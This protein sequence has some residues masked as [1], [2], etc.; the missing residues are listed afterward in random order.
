MKLLFQDGKKKALT[1]SYDDGTM[2]DIRF[3][4][5][6]DKNS[7]RCTFNISSGR[8][9]EEEPHELKGKMTKPTA[10]A[11]LKGT[12]H[13]VAL[14]GYNHLS[15]TELSDEEI[16]FQINEDRKNLEKD[17]GKVIRGFAFPYGTY[18][19]HVLEILQKLGITYAR[20]IYSTEKF[21]L[22]KTWLPLHPTCHHGCERLMELAKRF[23]EEDTN[24]AQ[25]FYLWGHSYEFDKSD[26]WY[27]IE[28][29]AK[30]AGNRDNI[31]YATNT[32]IYDYIKA[33][34]ALDVSLDGKTVKNP[35]AI[36]VFIEEDGK[37][38]CI[39]SGETII[40]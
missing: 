14:H 21:D 10:I 26:N 19:E 4:E 2:Q 35:S 36:D 1:L 25:M 11:L 8:Y 30:Y 7:I 12:P 18:N 15:L 22:P 32:E 6:L 5:I 33:F 3:K 9:P 17:F 13:E 23:V 28:E 38:V 34:E 20:S 24:E 29:F 39:K 40:L 16:V 31:W 27:V 37:A